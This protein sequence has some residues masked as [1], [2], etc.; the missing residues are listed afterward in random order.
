MAQ[1]QAGSAR[2][3]AIAL[4]ALLLVGAT[5]GAA[6]TPKPI[7]GEPLFKDTGTT[8]AKVQRM[9]GGPPDRCTSSAPG[10]WLCTW[11][12][13]PGQPAHALLAAGQALDRPI[14]LLCTFPEPMFSAAG[15]CTSHRAIPLRVPETLEAPP[16]EASID[17]AQDRLARQA[18]DGARTLEALS[19]LLGA[20]PEDCVQRDA[21]D[22]VCYWRAGP[23]DPGYATL[24]ALLDAPGAVRLVCLLPLDGGERGEDSCRISSERRPQS[25]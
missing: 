21:E 12:V 17:P 5:S 7:G 20:G 25:S 15:R 2:T 8:R 14:H 16:Q 6:Q 9:L 22:W 13:E 19:Q 23:D 18:I 24:G 4:G 1:W 10:R 11:R 3:S